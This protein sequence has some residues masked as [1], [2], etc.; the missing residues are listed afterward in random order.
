[1][2]CR[3][4]NYFFNLKTPKKKNTL[5]ILI[6]VF[7]LLSLLCEICFYSVE[8]KRG[9]DWGSPSLMFFTLINGWVIGLPLLCLIAIICTKNYEGLVSIYTWQ[10]NRP[11]W[12]SFWTLIFGYLIVDSIHSIFRGFINLHLEDI[13]SDTFAIYIYAC[14]RASI[15]TSNWFFKKS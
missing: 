6:L 5:Y 8:M 15:L 2:T 12:S 13:I 9:N 3:V 1:M 7:W 11:Y 10:K 4:L 14:L